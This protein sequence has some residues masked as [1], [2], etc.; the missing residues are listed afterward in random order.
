MQYHL[1]I[2]ARPLANSRKTFCKFPQN[3]LQ[4]PAK[5]SA[6]S[7]KTFCKFPQNLLQ[8]PAK[9]FKMKRNELFQYVAKG[10]AMHNW[11]M[12][13]ALF[14]YAE[15]SLDFLCTYQHCTLNSSKLTSM[16]SRIRTTLQVDERTLHTG[17]PVAWGVWE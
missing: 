12:V 9:A 6:N 10:V 1:Q 11:G 7:R 2:P 13:I 8:N 17:A 15:E 14:A 4:I 5:P 3:L 16:H